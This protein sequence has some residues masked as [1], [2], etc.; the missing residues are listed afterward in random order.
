MTVDEKYQERI[1]LCRTLRNIENEMDKTTKAFD[2]FFKS[3]SNRKAVIL[4]Y[5]DGRITECELGEETTEG[6]FKVIMDK[7]FTQKRDTIQALK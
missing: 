1:R 3:S 6:C 5:N 2:E 7:F 4:L